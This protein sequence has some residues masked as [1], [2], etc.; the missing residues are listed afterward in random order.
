MD[1]CIFCKIIKGEI[2]SKKFYEDEL[3]III[4]DVNPRAKKHYL[5]IPKKHYKFFSEMT[6]EDAANLAKIISKIAELA[7]SL[8]LENGYRVIVNQGDDAVQTVP[9]LHIHLLGGQKLGIGGFTVDE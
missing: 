2:P 3:M 8:G 4:A 5:A 6:E 1:N 7:P 9:H